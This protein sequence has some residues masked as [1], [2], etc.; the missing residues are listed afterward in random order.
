MIG[1]GA[2][3]AEQG[4]YLGVLVHASLKHGDDIQRQHS[5]VRQT[6]QTNIFAQCST[7]LK[8]TVSLH[9]LHVN[10]RL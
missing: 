2:K 7:A 6:N 1:V 10:I 4:K 5:L 3:L 9:L 8:K